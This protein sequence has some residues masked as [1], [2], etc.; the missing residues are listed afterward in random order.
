MISDN[1]RRMHAVLLQVL[2]AVACEQRGKF[3]TL[4]VTNSRIEIEKQAPVCML[5]CGHGYTLHKL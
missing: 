4:S 3:V 1:R 5:T 2:N